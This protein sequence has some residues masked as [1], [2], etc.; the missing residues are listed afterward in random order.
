MVTHD[1]LRDYLHEVARDR[2]ERA[3]LGHLGRASAVAI[4]HLEGTH[5]EVVGLLE[6]CRKPERLSGRQLADDVLLNLA[7]GAELAEH[8]IDGRLVVCVAERAECMESVAQL[9]EHEVLLFR[10]VGRPISDTHSIVAR[11]RLLGDA[12]ARRVARSHHT[13]LSIESTRHSNGSRS[14]C[15]SGWIRAGSS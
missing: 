6:P 4:E 7:P 1:E 11:L 14:R 3:E 9:V 12:H 8:R 10:S 2:C 13:R 5:H 15:G